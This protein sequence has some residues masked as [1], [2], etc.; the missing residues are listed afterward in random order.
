MSDLGLGVTVLSPP[1]DAEP[2]PFCDEAPAAYAARAARAKAAA[3]F[4]ARE[5]G[6]GFCASGERP[7]A[8]AVL[9]PD[10]VVIAAD[11]SVVLGRTI[12]GKPGDAG[13]ALEFLRALAGRTHEV[14]TGCAVQSADALDVFVTR[15]AVTM[16]N[17]PEPLLALYAASGEP[18][19]KAGG[20]AVQGAGAFLVERIEGSWS[21][22]VGLPLAELMQVLLRR[23]VLG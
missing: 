23:G 15:S 21:N 11:T 6:C 22:V 8:R 13:E 2:L 4:P 5:E 18:L 14:I 12:L 20:Y 10:A 1:A 16:W 17:C 7:H 3:F 9:P 19:D